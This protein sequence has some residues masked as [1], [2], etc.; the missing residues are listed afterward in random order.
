MMAAAR[1]SGEGNKGRKYGLLD[2]DVAL[3]QLTDGNWNLFAERLASI[4]LI[5][6]S[7]VIFV[8]AKVTVC[9]W[10]YWTA[11]SHGIDS[12]IGIIGRNTYFN[13]FDVFFFC[14]FLCGEKITIVGYSFCGG[15]CGSLDGDVAWNRLTDWNWNLLAE[16]L[17]SI[18]LICFS[19]VIFVWAKV[20]VGN[21]GLLDGDVA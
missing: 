7:F 8:W 11:K 21:W 9:N 1:C 6:F 14:K 15:K 16:R 18:Y 19:F 3:S 17:T 13:L 5:C 12:P 20:T 10:D 4:Y 2:G